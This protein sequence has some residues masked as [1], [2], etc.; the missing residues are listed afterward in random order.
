[1]IARLVSEHLGDLV[2]LCR[3]NHVQR[4]DLFGSAT[5]DRFDPE[6]SDLEFLVTYLPDA[7][8]DR[9]FAQ[10]LEPEEE[11][12]ALFGRSV[13]LVQDH[14]LRNPHFAQPVEETRTPIYTSA[15]RSV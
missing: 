8:P 12:S 15:S 13:D 1:M 10:F 6:T 9:W 14:E 3:R 7:K 5:T 2:E 4:L 11:P